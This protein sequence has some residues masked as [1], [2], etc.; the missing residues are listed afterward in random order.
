M[1]TS[2]VVAAVKA[3]SESGLRQINEATGIPV[4]TL[5]KIK[6][7]VTTDPRGSTVDALRAF[8]ARAGRGPA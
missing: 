6:Y 2:E 7:G 1:D 5:A 3:C 4:P 8:F